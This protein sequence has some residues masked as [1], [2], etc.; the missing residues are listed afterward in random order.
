M[1]RSAIFSPDNIFRH[2]L[3]RAAEE[4]NGFL[5]PFICLNPSKADAEKDDQS[6]RK[7]FGFARRFGYQ[8]IAVANLWDFRATKPKALKDAGWPKSEQADEW[9]VAACKYGDGPVVCAWGANA[10]NSSR[11]AEVLALIRERGFVPHALRWLHDGVPEHP[12]FLPNS[13]KMVP[14]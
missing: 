9:I 6:V 14:L 12:L 13:C 2:Q 7:M 4:G 10:R 5:L 1:R 8:G 3:I 11:P